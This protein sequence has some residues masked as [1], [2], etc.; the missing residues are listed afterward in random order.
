VRHILLIITLMLLSVYNSRAVEP[1]RTVCIAPAAKG[2]GFDLTC[3]LAA[4]TLLSTGLIDDAM[5][6]KHIPGGVGAI[7]YNYVVKMRRAVSNTIVAVST[8]SA[9]NIAQRKFGRYGAE[10]VRWLGALAVDYGAVIV[11]NDSKWENLNDLIKDLRSDPKSIIFGGGGSIGSQDWVKTA[12]L[13]KS[14]GTESKRLRYVS[15]EGGGEALTALGNRQIDVV[16]GD[17]SDTSR[18]KPFRILAVLSE[19]RL[20]NSFSDIPTAKEQGIDIVWPTW[21]GFYMSPKTPDSDYNWW[22]NTLRRLAR[23]EEFKDKL[24]EKAL[25]PFYIFGREFE[26]YVRNHIK[27]FKIFAVKEGLVD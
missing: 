13:A 2:G 23:T 18:S 21:R 24:D 14:A 16:S 8:G 3:S 4:E 12:M 22:V 11:R 20:M 19:Y 5:T 10:D 9:L 1:D 26:H 15:Y 27:Q 17:I 7:A 6:V 25:S